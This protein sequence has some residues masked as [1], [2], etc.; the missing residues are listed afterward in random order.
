[1]D[2]PRQIATTILGAILDNR[3]P[4]DDAFEAVPGGMEGRDRAFVRQLVTTTIRRLGHIDLLINECLT[5]PLPPKMKVVRNIL[6]LGITQLLYLDVPDHAAINTSVDLLSK[7][8][9]KRTSGFKGLVNAILRRITREGQEMLAKLDA[10]DTTPDWLW[11]GWVETYGIDNARAITLAHL[12][13]APLDITL[14]AGEDPAEW[15]AKLDANILA[16]GSLRRTS[17]GSVFDLSGYNEGHWWV[18]DA[19]ATLPVLLM[20]DVDG[21][22]IIDM[23]AAPGGK[24]LQLASAGA[25]VIAVDRSANRLQRVTENLRRLG[26]KADI[27]E[28]DGKRWQR[29]SGPVDAILLDAPCSTTGTLRRH[30]D[31]AWLKDETDVASMVPVQSAILQNCAGMVKP[32]GLL[33]YCVCSLQPEEGPDQI[34]KFLLAHPEFTRQ[35]IAADEPGMMPEFITPDGDVRTLPSHMADQGGIDGF[36]IARLQKNP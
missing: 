29:K 17:G 10:Y 12:V 25:R 6:R 31:V 18:Q 27:I 21:K 11:H 35:S 32:G 5:K 7:Q 15:A 16:N 33:I 2:M 28:A 20:G 19:G 1:M 24:T 36:Y 9:D 8:K 14:K 30:P 26:L 23:C 3:M 13:E 22:D 34:D 4:L